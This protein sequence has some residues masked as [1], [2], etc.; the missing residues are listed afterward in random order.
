MQREPEFPLALLFSP[1][2]AT[3]DGLFPKSGLDFRFSLVGLFFGF[4]ICFVFYL[5]STC[6]LWRLERGCEPD[7]GSLSAR[8]RAS[9]DSSKPGFLRSGF[10]AIGFATPCP[11]ISLMNLGSF[12]AHSSPTGAA[13]RFLEVVRPGAATVSAMASVLVDISI[14]L[15]GI[16]VASKDRRAST[17]FSK[18][19]RMASAWQW[20]AQPCL[21]QT[22]LLL[23]FHIFA[24]IGF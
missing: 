13:Y 15:V 9:L 2:C 3:L 8:N 18:D 10:A 21:G 17:T 20:C 4:G 7:S 14:I 6:G 1:L 5:S 19:P 24:P 23:P 22:S 12:E 11:G 16:I